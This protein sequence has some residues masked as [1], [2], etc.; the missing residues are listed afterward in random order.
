MSGQSVL[1]VIAIAS[2]CTASWDAMRGDDRVRFCGHCRQHVYNLSHMTRSEAEQF[3]K[4]R[5]GNVCAMFYRRFDG[6]LLT[7][8]CPIGWKK[9]RRRSLVALAGMAAFLLFILGAT[10]VASISTPTRRQ[11]NAEPQNQANVFRQVW[12]LIF[13]PRAVE[14]KVEEMK[15]MGRM[16]VPKDDINQAR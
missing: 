16:C 12:D 10:F 14:P 6:T 1:D 7:N 2:P 3:V 13:K 5:A 15:F 8:D 9:L 11:F 4:D